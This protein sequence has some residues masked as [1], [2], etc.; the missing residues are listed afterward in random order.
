MV[1]REA[2]E[3]VW[4]LQHVASLAVEAGSVTA[5][6]AAQWLDRVDYEGENFHG[7]LTLYIAAGIVPPSSQSFSPSPKQPQSVAARL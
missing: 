1:G 3:A 7:A 4:P 5:A 6:E 2:A